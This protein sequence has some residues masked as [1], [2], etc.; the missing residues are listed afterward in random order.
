MS[1]ITTDYGLVYNTDGSLCVTK[2]TDVVPFPGITSF[3]VE[4]RTTNFLGPYA[5][6][7]DSEQALFFP[8]SLASGKTWADCWDASQRAY[9]GGHKLTTHCLET[10]TID[11][12]STQ[13]AGTK[14]TLS[15]KHKGYL[16][17]VIFR[18][19]LTFDSLTDFTQSNT[20]EIKGDA[21]LD[22]W[23][24]NFGLHLTINNIRTIETGSPQR[25]LDRWYDVEITYTLPTDTRYIQIIWDF[26]LA[27]QANGGLGVLGYIRQPQL[28]IKPFA[29]SFVNGTRPAGRLVVPKELLG[30]NPAT[31]DWVVHYWKYP[32]ATRTNDLTGDNKCTIGRWSRSN[33]EGLIWWGKNIGSNTFSIGVVYNDSTVA[34]EESSSFD[35]AWYFRNWHYEV[36]LK[37]GSEMQYWI[38]GTLQVQFALAKPLLNN[39]V[40]GLTLGGANGETSDNSYIANACYGLYTDQWTPEFIQEQAAM[41]QGYY[42]PPRKVIE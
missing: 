33:L 9:V 41:T 22:H 1:K 39:F 7:F 21:S 36:F 5:W 38:D 30:F 20:Y 24:E 32:V 35:P 11:L 40:V 37:H 13:A 17:Y 3:A 14:V 16:W 8:R 12:G 27:Y 15:W 34:F 29:S 31:D 4:T 26:Y 10:K 25:L 2:R 42:V 23:E 6:E 18:Y 28:E 19:G